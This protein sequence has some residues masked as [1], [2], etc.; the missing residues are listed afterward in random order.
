MAIDCDPHALEEAAKC[1]KC[2]PAG[3]QTEVMIYLLQQ[4]SG[5]TD[6]PDQLMQKANCMRCI[7]RGMQSEVI[8]YLLCQIANA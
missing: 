6:T 2:V 3:A 8:T 5:N 4:I 7:P 1:F